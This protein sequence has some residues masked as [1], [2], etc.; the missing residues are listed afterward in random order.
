M[1]TAAPPL[2]ARDQLA[3]AESLLADLAGEDAA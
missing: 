2:T 3:L 1:C